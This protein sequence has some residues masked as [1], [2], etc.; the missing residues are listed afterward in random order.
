MPIFARIAVMEGAYGSGR[1]N[2]L[3]MHS[4]PSMKRN[5]RRFVPTEQCD[6]TRSWKTPLAYT[7]VDPIDLRTLPT[8]TLLTDE[9]QA[10]IEQLRELATK[11]RCSMLLYENFT[12]DH[13]KSH[14]PDFVRAFLQEARKLDM[15]VV[16]DDA[17]CS[18]RCGKFFSYEY[19]GTKHRPD[20]VL[21][22]KHWVVSALLSLD[23]P[24]AYSTWK[25]IRGCVTA[26]AD[27]VMIR[28]ALHF[29]RTA[30][31]EDLARRCETIGETVRKSLQPA[32]EKVSD[33]VLSGVGAMW[34]TNLR[35]CNEAVRRTMSFQRIT[36][37]FTIGLEILHD[38]LA[39][40]GKRPLQISGSTRPLL[41]NTLSTRK[42]QKKTKRTGSALRDSKRLTHA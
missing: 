5:T 9:E 28:R 18:V 21:V 17:M 35:L 29:V 10:A 32:C 26:E 19:Y 6:T 39:V 25:G 4:R 31:G 8:N 7:T 34:F 37:L 27:W 16:L 41:R 1:P 13:V 2:G 11:E 24:R 14:R 36:P 23:Q 38:I 15:L 42:S 20:L 30:K 33:A 12:S 40:D 3:G 22:G